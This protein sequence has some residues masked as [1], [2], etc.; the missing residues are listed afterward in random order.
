MKYT[1]HTE[2][3]YEEY[4][5]R[6]CDYVGTGQSMYLA[7]DETKQAGRYYKTLTSS[8]KTRRSYRIFNFT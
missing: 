5:Y 3:I 8:A 1:I 6:Q 4:H 2:K 7:T